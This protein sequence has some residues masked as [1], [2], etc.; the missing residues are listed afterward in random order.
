MNLITSTKSI[1]I[2]QQKRKLI[3]DANTFT[4]V[5]KHI[6]IQLLIVMC[7]THPGSSAMVEARSAIRNLRDEFHAGEVATSS[8]AVIASTVDQLSEEAKSK[9]PSMSTIP[10][11]A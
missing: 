11:S 8:R 1:K 4:K 3:G 5:V 2:I 10:S 9:L 6:S 7:H